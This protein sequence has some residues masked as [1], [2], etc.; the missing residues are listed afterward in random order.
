MRAKPEAMTDKPSKPYAGNAPAGPLFVYG[1]LMA[2]EKQQELLGRLCAAVPATLNGYKCH[3]G[4]WPYILSDAAE[5]VEGWVLMDL[6]LDDLAILDDY[7]AITPQEVEGKTRTLYKREQISANDENG[8][9][10][11][12]WVYHPLLT[13]WEQTWLAKE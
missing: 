1:T 6:T 12:C 5:K 8:Q 9:E 13:D 4:I 2:D 11:T 7:E 10:L 3:D